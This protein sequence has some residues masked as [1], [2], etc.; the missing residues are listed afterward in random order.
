MIGKRQ[1]NQVLPLFSKEET[2]EA[3]MASQQRTEPDKAER[4]NE[5]PAMDV[6]FMEEVCDRFIVLGVGSVENFPLFPA[7]P[8]PNP[9]PACG[10]PLPTSHAAKIALEGPRRLAGR[11]ASFSER[12]H[13]YKNP[14]PCAPE[15]AGDPPR[16]FQGKTTIGASD[17]WLHPSGICRPANFRG[18]S[19]T[20]GRS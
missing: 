8:T 4:G 16:P 9:S 13:R 2:G 15:V 10:S 19:G 20:K 6:G 7:N 14:C 17:R 18:P 5:D 1:K 12:R 3:W 11:P